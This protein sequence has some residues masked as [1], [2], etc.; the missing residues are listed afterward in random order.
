MTPGFVFNPEKGLIDGGNDTQDLR[1][2]DS[3]Q[4]DQT[5]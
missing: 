2:A 4:S 1:H 5:C 3:G